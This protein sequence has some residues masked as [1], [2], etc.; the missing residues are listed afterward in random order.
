MASMWASYEFNFRI[1][2]GNDDNDGMV[3]APV[4]SINRG[5]IDLAFNAG[6]VVS[7]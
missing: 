7:C 6:A 5:S 4:R 1:P 3:D 2:E